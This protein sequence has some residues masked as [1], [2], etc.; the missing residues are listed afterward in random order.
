MSE[1]AL[2]WAV[3]GTVIAVELATGTFYLL[4]LS[5]GLVAA[6]I[7][8]YMGATLTTQWVVASA[9]G[10]GAVVAWRSYK[11]SQPAEAPANANRNANLD[12]GETLQVDAWEA[13]GTS[14]VRYRGAQWD[15]A[16]MPGEIA[17]VGRYTVAEVV[18]SRLFVK[19][20]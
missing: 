20:T 14:K 7:A 4:M 6:A 9:V 10:G 3:A 12:V 2:W 11:K 1:S 19:K 15:V 8:A 13:D 16:L 17:S 5:V 18:G